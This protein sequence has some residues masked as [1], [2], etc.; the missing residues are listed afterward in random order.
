MKVPTPRATLLCV[1]LAY[2]GLLLVVTP[3]FLAPDEL[4]HFYRA[5]QISE[6]HLIGAPLPLDAQ[7]HPHTPFSQREPIRI[8]AGAVSAGGRRAVRSV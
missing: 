3:P 5:Y 2:G 1:G 6:G 4:A 8:A 7:S